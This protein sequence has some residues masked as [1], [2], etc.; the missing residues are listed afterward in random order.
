VGWVKY[1]VSYLQI[2]LIARL[3]TQDDN[4]E[5]ES[6]TFLNSYSTVLNNTTL[7]G[8]I[9]ESSDVNHVT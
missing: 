7:L 2:I 5:V 9:I 3:N 8:E 1:F 6:Y 4:T